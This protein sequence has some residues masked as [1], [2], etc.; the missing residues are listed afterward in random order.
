M[1]LT[2]IRQAT[3]VGVPRREVGGCKT[4]RQR[5]QMQKALGRC[6]HAYDADRYKLLIPLCLSYPGIQ[7]P[8]LLD[9]QYC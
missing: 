6:I 4:D 2:F 1:S 5:G 3:D 9:N 7:L 8:N